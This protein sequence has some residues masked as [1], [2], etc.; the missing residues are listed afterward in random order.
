MIIHLFLGTLEVEY[1]QLAAI[2]TYHKS[3]EK[4]RTGRLGIVWTHAQC[5]NRVFRPLACGKRP[6]VG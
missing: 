6:M 5:N 4:F 3:I 2:T 1:E